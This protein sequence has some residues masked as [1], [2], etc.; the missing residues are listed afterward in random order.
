[1]RDSSIASDGDSNDYS[2]TTPT[3]VYA[4]TQQQMY[5][6]DQA[7]LVESV[8]MPLCNN[9]A[10]FQISDFAI[11]STGQIY[12]SD[13]AST[14]FHIADASGTC[15]LVRTLAVRQYGLAFVP[16]GVLGPTEV[17]LGAGDDSNLYRI[18][19]ATGTLQLIGPFGSQAGDLAW[20]GTQLLATS[21]INT[22]FHLGVVNTTTGAFSD[23]GDTTYGGLYGLVFANGKLLAFS[24]T[25]GAIELDPLTGA[26][27]RRRMP[28]PA[29][30][31][32]S[33][34]P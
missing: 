23:L 11:S 21:L 10:G 1:M 4:S 5:L 22:S 9:V 16:P 2:G 33:G 3:M 18:N 31:G 27:V 19:T 30:Y 29:W 12:V 25:A 28:T 26:T 17:L 14:A 7:T 8:V 20:T 24:A 13:M 32:A 15:T 6:I 34:S